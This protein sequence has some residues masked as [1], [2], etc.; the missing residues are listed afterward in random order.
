VIWIFGGGRN[1][2]LIELPH[3]I[4]QMAASG[5]PSMKRKIFRIGILLEGADPKSAE[6][7]ATNQIFGEGSRIVSDTSHLSKTGWR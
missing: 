7:S 4:S 2:D 3:A 1:S 5:L 6:Q